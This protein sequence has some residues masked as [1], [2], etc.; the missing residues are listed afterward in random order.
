VNN[1]WFAVSG[2]AAKRHPSGKIESVSTPMVIKAVSRGEACNIAIK[3]ML[4]LYPVQEGWYNHQ[5][6]AIEVPPS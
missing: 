4:K 5:A 2:A 1:K 3:G 6:S